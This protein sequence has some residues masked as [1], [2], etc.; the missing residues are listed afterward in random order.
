MKNISPDTYPM[1]SVVIPFFNRIELTQRAVISVFAQTYSNLEVIIVNNGSTEDDSTIL[2]LF[3]ARGK[4]SY[5]YI[6]LQKNVGSAEARNIAVNTAIGRYIA[7]L[8]SDDTWETDKLKIQIEQMLKNGWQFSHTSYYRHDTRNDQLKTIRSGLNHYIFPWPA[9]HC[10]I[11]TPSVVLNRN[12][13]CGLSFRS[14][15]RFAY[16]TL[17]WLELSKRITLHGIDKPLT[18]VFVGNL[19]TALNNSIQDEALRLLAM[20]GLAGHHFLLAIHALYRITRKIQR[21]IC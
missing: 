11:A 4:L 13:L 10:L 5:K 8:D 3:S 20:D 1:V 7:F 17:L 16:D 9:F 19:T 18:H 14:D 2:E 15:L 6:K 12:L 21:R